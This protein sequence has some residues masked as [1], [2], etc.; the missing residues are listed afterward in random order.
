MT[1]SEASG[2]FRVRLPKSLHAALTK[3]ARE[4]GAS[5]NTYIVMLLSAKCSEKNVLDTYS[6]ITNIGCQSIVDTPPK[7]ET[8]YIGHH[9][10]DAVESN[11]FYFSTIKVQ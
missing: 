9:H 8:L 6:K 5:L 7:I 10:A 1:T 3:Q 2:Q 4:E 11:A